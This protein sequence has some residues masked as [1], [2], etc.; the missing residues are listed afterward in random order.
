MPA[1][2]RRILIAVGTII[3]ESK[4]GSI[5]IQAISSGIE[6][7][8]PNMFKRIGRPKG[9]EIEGN[10]SRLIYKPRSRDNPLR[11]LTDCLIYPVLIYKT[12]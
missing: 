10:G 5:V 3:L 12:R 11:S 1:G 4:P 6:K 7:P 9:S 2:G 8:I